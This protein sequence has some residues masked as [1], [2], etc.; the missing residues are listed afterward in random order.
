MSEHIITE[1]IDQILR[2]EITRP[3]K[4]NAL[5][6]DM[7]RAMADAING[8]DENPSIRVILIHGQKDIFTAGSDLKDA[9]NALPSNGSNPAR[10]FMRAITNAKKPLIAAVGGYA[11]GIGTTML[12]HFD[13]VYAGNNARFQLPFV[14]LGLCPEFG[15]GYMLPLLAGHHCAAELFY[16]GDF[17]SAQDMYRIGLVNKIFSEGN[18]LEKVMVEARRLANQPPASVRLTKSLMKRHIPENLDE[19]IDYEG[20]QFMKRLTSPEAKEAFAAFYERRKPDFSRF[21]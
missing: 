10:E 1:I 11:V 5:T 9:Q 18:L 15:S 8:A 7:Y 16:F 20:V 13:L 12:F 4:R 19:I 17:L 21:Q 14:S 3:K 2:I 6:R